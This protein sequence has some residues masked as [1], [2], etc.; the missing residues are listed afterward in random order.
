MPELG[1]TLSPCPQPSGMERDAEQWGEIH[2]RNQLRKHHQVPPQVGFGAPLVWWP[3]GGPPGVSGG[4][5]PPQ[6]AVPGA[7]AVGLFPG[8]G[9]SPAQPASPSSSTSLPREEERE[10]ETMEPTQ[11]K[12]RE[13]K[14]RAGGGNADVRQAS[15]TLSRRQGRALGGTGWDGG[16]AVGPDP[17]GHIG[18]V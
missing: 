5:S 10:G 8:A 9:L 15:S 12:T 14:M 7:V 6:E 2:G 17:S 1:W 13:S 3:H 4:L 16:D 18:V 11:S